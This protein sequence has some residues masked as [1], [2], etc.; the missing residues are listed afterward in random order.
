M[1][2]ILKKELVID[3]IICGIYVQEHNTID[4]TFKQSESGNLH[5][6]Q[7]YHTTRPQLKGLENTMEFIIELYRKYDN[8][9][10]NLELP[11]GSYKELKKELL[12]WY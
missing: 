3:G 9:L 12:A 2:T 8:M 7:C 11:K 10:P 4:F 5:F 6:I 1:A